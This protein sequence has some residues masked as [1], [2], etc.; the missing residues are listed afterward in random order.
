LN[1]EILDQFQR[2]VAQ[3]VDSYGAYVRRFVSRNRR[4]GIKRLRHRLDEQGKLQHEVSSAGPR[5][6]FAV[7]TFLAIEARGWKGSRGTALANQPATAAM[8]RNFLEHSQTDGNDGVRMRADMLLLDE[9]PIAISIG[10]VSCG[11]GFMWKIA[12]D[13]SYRRFAPGVV[14]ED[15]ILQSAHQSLELSQLDSATGPGTI[16][17]SLYGDRVLMGD[18]VIAPP[19]MRGFGALL[20]AEKFRRRL[21]AALKSLRNRFLRRS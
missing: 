18:L 5:L 14:L 4:K 16:L 17:E 12:L 19:S 8:L 13:D 3:I 2:P 9:Q 6:T 7:E 20:A 11:V 21:R 15:A 1:Y 10:F